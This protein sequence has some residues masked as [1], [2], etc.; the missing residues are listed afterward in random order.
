MK[1]PSV[2]L[3]H[4]L[5]TT[6]ARMTATKAPLREKKQAIASSPHT[7]ITLHFDSDFKQVGESGQPE[8][9]ITI[10]ISTIGEKQFF[11]PVSD[12]EDSEKLAKLVQLELR[13][14]MRNFDKRVELLVA[15]RKLQTR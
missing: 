4:I 3:I 2:K 7:N 12:K 11:R 14:A 9:S 6:E 1:H 8:A 10:S 13:K 15:K 5:E